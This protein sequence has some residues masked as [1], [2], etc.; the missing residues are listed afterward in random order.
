MISLGLTWLFVR[1][2]HPSL[3]ELRPLRLDGRLIG[4]VSYALGSFSKEPIAGITPIDEMTAESGAAARPA[5][6]RSDVAG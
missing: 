1:W 6:A 3:A 4:A 5:A 2:S